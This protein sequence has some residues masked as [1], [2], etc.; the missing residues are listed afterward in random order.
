MQRTTAFLSLFS[1]CISEAR[2][3][4]KCS[5]YIIPVSETDLISVGEKY[6]KAALVDGKLNCDTIA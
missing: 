3:R 1:I 5:F 4:Q 2:C 6:S